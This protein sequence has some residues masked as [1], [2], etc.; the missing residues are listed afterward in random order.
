MALNPHVVKKAQQDL[1]MVVGGDRLPELS[2]Q[3]DLPYISAIVKELLRWA[4]PTPI[5]V[6]KRVTEDDTY[7]GY[8]IPA[9][10]T[11]IENIW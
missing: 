8:F 1:D 6:P 5:R 3:D 11:V 10:T 9:G 2:D 7:D 4:C